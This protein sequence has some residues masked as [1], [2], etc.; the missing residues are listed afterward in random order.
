MFWNYKVILDQCGSGRHQRIRYKRGIFFIPW[1]VLGWQLQPRELSVP[2]LFSLCLLPLSVRVIKGQWLSRLLNTYHFKEWR[3]LLFR[4]LRSVIHTTLS[5]NWSAW[6]GEI[7]HSVNLYVQACYKQSQITGFVYWGQGLYSG[8][9]PCQKGLFLMSGDKRHRQWKRI[10][11]WPSGGRVY[12]T[13][14]DLR[15]RWFFDIVEIYFNCCST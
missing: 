14:T 2:L 7:F 8:L 12:S 4:F 6:L 10:F 15:G 1:K 3:L 5:L 9:S 13:K 11:L